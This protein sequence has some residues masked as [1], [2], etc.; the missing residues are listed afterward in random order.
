MDT[1]SQEIAKT[2]TETVENTRGREIV[3]RKLKPRDRMLLMELI[4]GENA[5][6]GPYLGYATLAYSVE[7][8]DGQL[9]P[10]PRTK[11]A[12]EALVQK[13]DDEG[14]DAIGEAFKKIYPSAAQAADE[15]AALKNE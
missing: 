5:Q 11:V 2:V 7:S 3:V 10:A 4:G 8:I 9:Q 6:N 1:P 14:L 15:Q 13:L 12:L